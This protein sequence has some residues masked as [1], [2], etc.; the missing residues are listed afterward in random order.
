M[1]NIADVVFAGQLFASDGLHF[2]SDLIG[3]E[4]C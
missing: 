2:M 4:T 1:L 3:G